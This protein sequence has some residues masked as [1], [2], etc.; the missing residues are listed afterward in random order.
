M[1]VATHDQRPYILLGEM[2]LQFVG[3]TEVGMGCRELALVAKDM[4]PLSQGGGRM[5][6]GAA[7][8]AAWRRRMCTMWPRPLR[9]MWSGAPPGWAVGLRPQRDP[10]VVQPSNPRRRNPPAFANSIRNYDSLR[11]Q[12]GEAFFHGVRDL[13][14]AVP[15]SRLHHLARECTTNNLLHAF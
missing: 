5:G 3:L 14:A 9:A 15:F 13:V 11:G 10:R 7:A 4:A 6:D 1:R 12:R 8:S 2:V